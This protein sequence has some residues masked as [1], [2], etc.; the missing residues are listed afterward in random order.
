M[1]YKFV[2]ISLIF[3]LLSF[4]VA[5]RWD[6]PRHGIRTVD[7]YIPY[8]KVAANRGKVYM[9]N[10]YHCS[11]RRNLKYCVDLKGR[12]LTGQIVVTDGKLVAY[13][14][15]QNGYQNGET[16]IFTTD[17]NL[18]EQAWYK[19]G[20]RDGEAKEYYLNGN[21]WLIKHYDSG[22]LHG[23]VEEYDVN[24]VLV[25]KMTYKKGWFKDG[26]CANEKGGQTMHERFKNSKYNQIIP[27]NGSDSIE[28]M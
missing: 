15:Y 28:L 10:R 22:M 3:L 20:L 11:I 6:E 2:L 17:G 23:R 24:G 16:S 12:A 1:R 21:V 8:F 27:C 14:T 5:A 7:I 4:P 13:E 26:Y 25:G 19:K 18:A 9:P